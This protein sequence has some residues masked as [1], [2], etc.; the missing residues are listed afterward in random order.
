MISGSR[1]Y[2]S[3]KSLIGLKVYLKK[4]YNVERTLSLAKDKGNDIPGIEALEDVIITKNVLSE[5][6]DRERPWRS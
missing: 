3:E 1:E 4:H 5:K 6:L 2:Q